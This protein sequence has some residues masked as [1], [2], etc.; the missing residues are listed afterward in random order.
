MLLRQENTNLKRKLQQKT[1]E[2]KSAEQEIKL[3]TEKNTRYYVITL[4][5]GSYITIFSSGTEWQVEV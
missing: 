3:L 2:Y 5:L 1:Q 4:I